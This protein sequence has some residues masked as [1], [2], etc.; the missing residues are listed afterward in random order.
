MAA[1]KLVNDATKQ[2][3]DWLEAGKFKEG[4]RLPSERVIVKELGVKPY[5]LN[6][7]MG[8]LIA[9]GRIERRGYRLSL[10][11]KPRDPQRWVF[12]LIVSRGTQHLA[13][14][15]RAADN[16]DIELAVH[17]WEAVEDVASILLQLDSKDTAGVICDPPFEYE[18]TSWVQAAIQLVRH[19]IPVVCTGSWVAT[20][21]LSSVVGNVAHGVAL[22]FSHLAG[23]GHREIA[24]VTFPN[25][26]VAGIG[27]EDYWKRLC[28]RGNLDS[29]EGRI[30][31]Q[32]SGL[33]VPDEIDALV[34]SLTDGPWKNV[35]GLVILIGHSCSIQSFFKKLAR[36]GR[37]V[38]E[39][40]SVV[41]VGN[42]RTLHA[43]QPRVTAASIDRVLWFE[44]TLDLL[45]REAR[46]QLKFGV[47]GEPSGIQVM[48][49]L[50]IRDSTRAVGKGAHAVVS[51]PSDHPKGG[52]ESGGSSQRA[53]PLAVKVSL[54]ERPRFTP[55]NLRSF[56]NR[57]LI[58]R[59]GWLGDIPLRCLAPG[60][61]EIH[62]IPFEILG[63]LRR[64][65][66]GAIV[67]Q[68]TINTTGNGQ[69]LPDRLIIP[70]NAAVEAVYILH[71]CGYAKSMQPFASYS[72]HTADGV[73][74]AV[75]LVSLGR[76]PVGVEIAAGSDRTEM[77]ANIQDWWS[78]YP[79][80]DF[81]HARMVP[82]LE[83]DETNHV[84]R[85]VFL[86]TLE[87]LNPSPKRLITH[88]EIAVVPSVPTTLGVLAVTLVG[89]KGSV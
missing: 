44:L 58:F 20:D 17:T 22:G 16:L 11:S 75:P 31:F 55:V 41:V 56:A 1:G 53:Y 38:P 47:P 13:S 21:E 77:R 23:I 28:A 2:L 33:T 4:D 88:M 40:L 42:A 25:I 7:A 5:S 6:R 39:S 8:R 67:F 78:D 61:H 12:H 85:H 89:L 60:T 70:V 65:D 37:R 45:R 83:N 52:A 68:S 26:S 50:T 3:N 14:Y 36:R 18:N 63:G 57:T 86:Y 24:L 74:G 43:A 34:A 19:G 10:A 46:D 72:F 84:N 76:P 66:A 64:A 79:H 29:S 30:L 62:G 51:V 27:V 82:L 59:H 71:G 35:T 49:R 54:A 9:A 81:P 69:K 80:E 48:P 87:W 73:V 15:R 32:H